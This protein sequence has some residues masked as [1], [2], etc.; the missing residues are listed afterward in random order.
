[1][2][3]LQAILPI[4]DINHNPWMDFLTFKN[5]NLDIKIIFE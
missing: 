4:L 5:F 2:Q 1:M 3:D